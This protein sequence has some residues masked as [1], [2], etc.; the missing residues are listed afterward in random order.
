MQDQFFQ[1]W[2]GLHKNNIKEDSL[3][4]KVTF[5]SWIHFADTDTANETNPWHCFGLG[6]SHCQCFSGTSTQ[7]F[8]GQNPNAWDEFVTFLLALS[9]LK[10]AYKPVNRTQQRDMSETLSG[11][12]KSVKPWKN[13]LPKVRGKKKFE[14]RSFE[15]CKKAAECFFLTH[16]KPRKVKLWRIITIIT[17]Q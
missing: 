2:L 8:L 7:F 11:F 1:Q 10:L 16:V 3:R 14:P 5:G 15:S 4:N 17:A 12:A 13:N 6:S 9:C